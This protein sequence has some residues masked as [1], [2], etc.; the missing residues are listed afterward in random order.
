MRWSQMH[1]PTL[2]DDPAGAEVASHRLLVRAGYVRQLAAGHYSLLPLAVRV[3]A[4]VIGIIRQ[5]M[6]RIGAQELLAP[7]M[8]P[9]EIWRR[10]GRWDTMADVMF[11]LTDHKG[12]VN[13]LSVTNEE[14]FTVL[15][16]ELNSHRQLPQAWY[17]FQTKFRDEPRPRAGLM[18][19]REFTMKDSYTFDL[20]A[21]GLDAAFDRHRAAYLRIFERLGIPVIPV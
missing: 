1:I 13:V 21:A 16:Q 8:H 9:E 5:E 10:S 7:S 14:I 20:D 11:R 12:A 2:R 4:K 3:R 6:D 17:Q 18:R 19:V 15:A